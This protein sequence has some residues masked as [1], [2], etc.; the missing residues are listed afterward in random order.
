MGAAILDRVERAL[1][2]ED[3]DLDPVVL[4]QAAGQTEMDVPAVSG[5]GIETPAIAS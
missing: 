4:D 5:K 3:A 2:V 1:A